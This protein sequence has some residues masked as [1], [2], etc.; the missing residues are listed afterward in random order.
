MASHTEVLQQ[1]LLRRMLASGEASSLPLRFR[2]DVV[3]KYRAM[4]GAQVIRTRTVGRVALRGQW[5]LD[6]GI[7]ERDDIPDGPQVQVTFGD[8]LLRLPERERDHWIAHLVAGPASEN[9]L[10][11]KLTANACIDDGE[12][13]AWT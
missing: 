11:T 3:A 5:S 2:A 8:L 12:T 1:T 13:V 7:I 10:Q 4:E 9:F 6:M